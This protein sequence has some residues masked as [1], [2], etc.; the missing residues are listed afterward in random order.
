MPTPANLG[1]YV[2]LTLLSVLAAVA[3]LAAFN[4]HYLFH[5]E[6]YEAADPA[7]N[8]LSIIRA[9]HFHEIYGT[10]SR[11]RFH[12]PGPAV[13]YF[14][15][16]MEGI[17]F[18]ALH[19][20]PTPY[21]AQVLG[22]AFL[23]LSFLGAGIGVAARW[24]RSRFFVPLALL[25]A[26]LHF[27][28]INFQYVVLSTWPACVLP[29]IFFCLLVATASVLAG[30]GE[31]LPLMVTAGSLAIHSHVA[32]PLFVL[33]MFILGYL[34]L[35][36][37]CYRAGRGE[38]TA[39]GE[40]RRTVPWRRFPRAHVFAGV[41]AGAFLLP[42]LVDLCKGSQSN[43]AVIL[44]HLRSQHGTA[45]PWIDSVFYLLHFGAYKASISSTA[46][47]PGTQP[48]QISRYFVTHPQMTLLWAGAILSPLLAVIV[49]QFRRVPV[50]TP[51]DASAPAP[52]IVV[53][54]RP[55]RWRFLGA[56]GLVWIVSVGLTLVWGHI[57]DGDMFYYNAWFNYSIYFTLALLAAVALSDALESVASRSLTWGRWWPAG[58]GAL[59]VLG[60]ALV[61]VRH[62]DQ[63]R[64]VDCSGPAEMTQARTVFAALRDRPDAPRT[65]LLLFPNAAGWQAATGIAVILERAGNRPRV[66]E[67][68]AV[69]FGE[70]LAFNRSRMEAIGSPGQE[71]MDIW[72]LL[73]ATAYPELGV[74]APLVA[75]FAL[76]AGGTEID[77]A[78]A[79]TISF[80]VP[81]ANTEVFVLY[82][83]GQPEGQPGASF[84]WSTGKA[85][86]VNFRAVPVPAEST[87][88][89]VFD[90][91]PFVLPGRK[92]EQRLGVNW[93]GTDLGTFPV[94]TDA[95]VR[96]SIPA[97][98]WNARADVLL[99]LSF[100]DAITPH[101]I[102]AQSQDTR[103]LAFGTRAIRFQTV[104]PVVTSR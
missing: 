16:A 87:V 79:G 62:R 24:T 32:Q 19:V 50:I 101:D 76:L 25:L 95:P 35:T 18:R 72:R 60:V 65:K 41:L 92:D 69:M 54:P 13:F 91:F 58:C 88:E 8:T 34:G 10:Y 28:A 93:N 3:A 31:D 39:E 103:L 84:T 67:D 1:K 96:V 46:L 4:S 49:R 36:W 66:L 38:A 20:I 71:P 102:D 7:A 77:P 89:M 15:A 9:S 70:D 59:C 64:A 57:Q 98:V 43:F 97:A 78:H 61:C 45:H 26:A 81:T 37:A 33:P 12:H 17:F 90:A 100:P 47:S 74:K 73:P 27:S 30:Q 75:G 23:T 14:Q 80:G 21:N 44:A 42:L 56:L 86:A 94:R 51:T 5:T 2:F 68:W 82:G 6:L 22:T 85:A 48:G 53:S 104:A 52:A 63:W 40:K 55:A 99:R 11:W 83:W 29:L